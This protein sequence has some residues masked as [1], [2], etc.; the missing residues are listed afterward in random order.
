LAQI[1]LGKVPSIILPTRACC[2]LEVDSLPEVK[3]YVG[4]VKV[5]GF[6]VEGEPPGVF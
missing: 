6:G 1:A 5:T 4:D 3:T 2:G